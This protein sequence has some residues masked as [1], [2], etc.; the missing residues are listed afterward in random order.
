M[1]K[2]SQK[3]TIFAELKR[4]YIIALC[5]QCH[6]F[7]VRLAINPN[8]PLQ[9]YCVRRGS[10]SKAMHIIRSTGYVKRERVTGNMVR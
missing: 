10:A 2:R 3:P 4:Q 8:A 9:N 6:Y 5:K 1:H 7:G